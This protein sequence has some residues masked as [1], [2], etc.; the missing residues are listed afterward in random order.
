[1]GLEDEKEEEEEDEEEEEE[2]QED[3]RG[4]RK[5]SWIVVQI[6]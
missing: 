5:L 1:M 2:E 3:L 4:M 6:R